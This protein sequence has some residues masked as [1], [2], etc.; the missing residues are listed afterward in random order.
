MSNKYTGKIKLLGKVTILII[1]VVHKLNILVWSLR[2]S[3]PKVT[4]FRGLMTIPPPNIT[5][6]TG[7]VYE[8]YCVCSTMTDFL[9]EGRQ[10]LVE[11]T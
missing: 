11:E 8:M 4:Y 7:I 3:V 5:E 6:W 2:N 10:A 9:M 1:Y